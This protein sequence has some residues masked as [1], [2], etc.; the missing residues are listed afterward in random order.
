MKNLKLKIKYGCDGT[1][2]INTYQY[3]LENKESST[4]SL[5]LMSMVLL[6]LQFADKS[7]T[8]WENLRTSSLNSCLP[9]SFHFAPK[10]KDRIL[11][12]LRNIKKK[13]KRLRAGKIAINHTVHKVEYELMSTMID[14]K[15][16]QVT[17][18]LYQKVLLVGQSPQKLIV[19]KQYSFST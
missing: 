18:L 3:K 2:G 14:G 13:I 17:L 6:S 15:V 16:F 19:C 7:I 12:K 10:T 9:I 11:N 5:F 8:V 1:S 4:S